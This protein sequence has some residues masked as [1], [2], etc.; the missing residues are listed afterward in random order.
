MSKAI[1]IRGGTVVNHDHSKRADVLVEG[2][3]IIAVE[4]KIEAP[5][6]AEVIDAGCLW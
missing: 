2:G 6:G 1:L 3:K 5:K 4:S